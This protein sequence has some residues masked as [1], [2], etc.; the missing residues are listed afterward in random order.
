MAGVNSAKGGRLLWRVD[1]AC[2][3][4]RIEDRNRIAPEAQVAV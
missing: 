3:R 4:G 1:E 2:S